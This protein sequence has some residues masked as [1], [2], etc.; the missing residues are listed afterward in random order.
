MRISLVLLFGFLISSAFSQCADSTHIFTFKFNNKK[1]E[2]VKESKSFPAAAICAKERG[3]YLAEIN[4]KA[5]QA[6]VFSAVLKNAGIAPNYVSVSTGGGAAYVWIGATDKRTEGIWLWDGNN[7][8]LGVNFWMGEGTNGAKNGRVMLEAYN[9][10]GGTSKGKPVEPD[11]FAQVQ[12][13]AGMAL[14]GW[15]LKTSSIGIAGEW[16]DLICSTLLYYVI[17]Y[18]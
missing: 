10:W 6:A 12:N 3:G 18:D 2:V 4:N 8:A 5:E 14:V 1:Y 7:D 9:N 15:P 17:E 16:N 11:N 13:C